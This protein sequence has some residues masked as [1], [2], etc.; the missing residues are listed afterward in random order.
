MS[1]VPPR[2]AALLAA[3]VLLPVLTA[4]SCSEEPSGVTVGERCVIGANSVVTKDL[5]PFTIAAG[6]PAKPI[7]RVPGAPGE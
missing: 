2:A 7:G 3:C 1:R 6:M 5:E 4:A